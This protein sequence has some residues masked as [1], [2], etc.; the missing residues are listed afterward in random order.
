MSGDARGAAVSGRAPRSG[1][2]LLWV[3]ASTFG[4]I[5]GLYVV[6]SS[7]TDQAGPVI[8]LI[9]G[10][11]QWAVLRKRVRRSGWWVWATA[12]GWS[13]GSSLGQTTAGLPGVAAALVTGALL[14]LAMGAAQWPVLRGSVP[15]AIWWVPASAGAWAL[16]WVATWL[17]DQSAIPGSSAESFLPAVGIMIGII[18][19]Y[20][21]VRLL[22]GASRPI[23]INDL[24]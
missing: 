2:G 20:P 23:E 15:E 7:E 3:L 9:L 6:Q 12:A 18:S 21:L 14:G 16:T 4:W 1:I 5:A 11:A 10:A 13:I 19:A 17:M 24:H 22:A 8:G